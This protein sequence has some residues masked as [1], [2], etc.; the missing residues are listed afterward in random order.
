MTTATAPVT[1]GGVKSSPI[2][3][4]QIDF[5][6]AFS[7]TTGIDPNVAVAWLLQEEGTAHTN[8]DPAAHGKYN[9]LNVGVTGK[10]NF[11]TGNAIWNTPA[12]AGTA[13]GLWLK[14]QANADPGYAPQAGAY[15]GILDA[16]A[17]G[18]EAQVEA[19]QASPFAASHE[20]DLGSLYDKVL[21]SGG[22]SAP[23]SN[24]TAN[25][26]ATGLPDLS[27]PIS[28]PLNS[29]DG[30]ISAISS[31]SFWVR[32]AEIVGGFILLTIALKTLT[33]VDVTPSKVP[34]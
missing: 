34:V 7:Q 6:Q 25:A 21:Q 14:G 18:P 23:G 9:F 17:K 20:P 26:S 2:T 4:E 1:A 5:A 28:N 15:K 27:N 8:T 33:G 32:A 13:T 30:L 22:V 10:G 11:G 29:V 19:I 16:V 31:A 3:Q 12:G 24:P